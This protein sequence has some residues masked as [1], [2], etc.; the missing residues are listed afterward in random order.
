MPVTEQN[1]TIKKAHF[2]E[3][4]SKKNQFPNRKK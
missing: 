3:K 4:Y 2:N 1:S